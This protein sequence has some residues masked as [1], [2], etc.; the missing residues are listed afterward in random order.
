MLQE[1]ISEYENLKAQLVTDVEN[2]SLRSKL[3]II[4]DDITQS[5]SL[6]VS[7]DYR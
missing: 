2:I 5:Q 1:V 6:P 3:K 4:N 7:I